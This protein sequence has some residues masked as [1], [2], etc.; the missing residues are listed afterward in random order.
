MV[1]EMVG[2][3]VRG[4]FG[5]KDSC[6]GCSL[7]LVLIDMDMNIDEA[8]FSLV[9]AFT[10]LL[11]VLVSLLVLVALD[12]AAPLAPPAFLA[13]FLALASA[14]FAAFLAAFAAL[15]VYIIKYK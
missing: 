12:G 4:A 13:A 11:L 1:R 8:F 5:L 10:L 14:F 7:L 2:R 6:S 3:D 15:A 9:V